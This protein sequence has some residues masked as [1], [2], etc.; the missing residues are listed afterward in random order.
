MQETASRTRRHLSPFLSARVYPVFDGARLN[1][2]APRDLRDARSVSANDPTGH[3]YP[4]TSLARLDTH[5]G[6][7]APRRGESRG[8]TPTRRHC[9]DGSG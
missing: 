1:G 2:L 9:T 7:T 5:A 4:Q 8:P 3:N 6:G